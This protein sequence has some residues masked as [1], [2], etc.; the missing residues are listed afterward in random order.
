[1]DTAGSGE[2]AL[3]KVIQGTYDLITLDIRMAVASGLEILSPLR[4]ICPHAVIAVIS[5]HIAEQPSMDFVSYAVVVLR[6]PV[7]LGKFTKLLAGAERIHTT[8]EEIRDLGE[9][10][11]QA[12]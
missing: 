5:W 3:G 8:M 2:E 6:K 4:N 1:M 9:V 10:T 7:D 11:L 12:S